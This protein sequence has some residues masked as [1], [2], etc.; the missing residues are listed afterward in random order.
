M[1]ERLLEAVK[2]GI[3]GGRLRYSGGGH[4]DDSTGLDRR[5]EVGSKYKKTR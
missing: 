2:D 5:V 4:L 1:F 3:E